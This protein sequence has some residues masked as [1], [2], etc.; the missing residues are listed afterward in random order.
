[1]THDNIQQ[2]IGIQASQSICPGHVSSEKSKG[3]NRSDECRPPI[4][5]EYYQ[6]FA[7]GISKIHSCDGADVQKS[8]EHRITQNDK[9]EPLERGAYLRNLSYYLKYSETGIFKPSHHAN[10]KNYSENA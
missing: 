3:E 2:K 6:L 5:S 7:G 10:D 1:M 4:I 8:D 9:M